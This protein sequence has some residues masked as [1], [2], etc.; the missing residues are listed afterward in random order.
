MTVWRR[1][2]TDREDLFAKIFLL[3]HHSEGQLSFA[4]ARKPKHHVG[5]LVSDCQTWIASNCRLT[6]PVTRMVERSG[7]SERTFTRWFRNA[8]GYSP[9][10]FI[11]TLRIEKA[12]HL[13]ETT[14]SSVE[15]I[16]VETGYED[17]SFFRRLFKRKVGITPAR[18]P[19]RLTGGEVRFAH[20]PDFGAGGQRAAGGL[21]D[22]ADIFLEPEVLTFR[23]TSAPRGR[24]I[25]QRGFPQR[26]A[27]AAQKASSP[28]T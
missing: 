13:L 22:D 18:Y 14:V 11:Q 12:K 19:Q 27:G 21:F 3:G 23:A 25:V 6:T 1:R 2:R 20:G 10:E 26:I 17:M 8:T 24:S 16:A 15:M 28:S 9:M 4:G 7:L 5:G